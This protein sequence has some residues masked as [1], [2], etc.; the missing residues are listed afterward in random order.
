MCLLEA[1]FLTMRWQNFPPKNYPT[2]VWINPVD[3]V[4]LRSARALPFTSSTELHEMTPGK[5]AD[6]PF[7]RARVLQCIESSYSLKK[8]TPYQLTVSR[9]MLGCLEVT[10]VFLLIFSFPYG[11]LERPFTQHQ[12]CTILFSRCF[13]LSPAKWTV[14]GCVARGKHTYFYTMN[15]RFAVD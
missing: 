15:R 1:H 7:I 8:T 12:R 11:I 2:K 13:P 9:F 14:D 5:N 4:T 3:R 6:I 10:F